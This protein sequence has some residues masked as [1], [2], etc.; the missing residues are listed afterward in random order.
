M[1][2]ARVLSREGAEPRVSRFFF[3][4]YVQLVLLFGA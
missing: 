2:M 4:A 1:R 3:E